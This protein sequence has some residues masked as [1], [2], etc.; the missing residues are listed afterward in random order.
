MIVLPD[1]HFADEELNI[2]L[3]HEMVHYKRKDLIVKSMM[4]VANALHWFNPAVYALNRQLNV[5]CEL[6]CDA[7]TIKD[8]DIDTRQLY[9]KAII[10]VV[11]CK[12]NI[13]TALSTNFYGGKKGM[14]KR[15]FTIMDSSRKKAGIAIFSFVLIIT[16]GAGFVFTAN[17]STPTRLL[18]AE[19]ADFERLNI[20]TEFENFIPPTLIFVESRFY[21][22]ISEYAMSMEEA[23]QLGAQYIWDIFG[24]NIDGMY[25][26]MDYAAPPYMNRTYWSGNIAHSAETVD[27]ESDFFHPLYS[28]RI[29]AVTGERIDINYNGPELS[30]ELMDALFLGG[31]IFDFGWEQMDTSA[32]I[33]FVGISPESIEAYTQ[34]A[35]ELLR[36]HFNL[37][38]IDH[39]HFEKSQIMGIHTHGLINEAGELVFIPDS[40]TFLFTDTSTNRRAVVS[41]PAESGIRRGSSISTWLNDVISGPVTTIRDVTE[42]FLDY[43]E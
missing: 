3:A 5:E 25:I 20:N 29:D 8:T 2:I 36:R 23:S 13:K 39:I 31:R 10:N 15:I 22:D 42:M 32:R 26:Q 27:S 4:L 17:G 12:S 34:V 6:S 33:D 9:S 37:S 1:M 28:F 19:I 16:L 30:E 11:Q 38:S 40:L 24:T 21:H 18:A 43:E 41:I 14:K 7:E 35:K